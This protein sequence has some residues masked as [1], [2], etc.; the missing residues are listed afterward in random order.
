MALTANAFE[1][2]RA[3]CLAAG[4]DFYLAKPVSASQLRN[5]IEDCLA[6]GVVGT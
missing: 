1:E 2:D 4:F 6:R 5:A 3:A